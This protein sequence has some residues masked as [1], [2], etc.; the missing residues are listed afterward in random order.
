MA[1]QM[2]IGAAGLSTAISLWLR[3]TVGS[4]VVSLGTVSSA[5]PT[6]RKPRNA[7]QQA[8]YSITT[9]GSDLDC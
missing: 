2:T 6:G 5:S 4:Y 3:C 8:A 1:T 7:R 9:S